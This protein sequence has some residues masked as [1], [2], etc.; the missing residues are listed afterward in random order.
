MGT[1]YRIQE[2]KTGE[3][4]DHSHKVPGSTGSRNGVRLLMRGLTQRGRKRPR[5]PILC[6]YAI[7]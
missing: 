5:A 6:D 7:D 1:M 3:T 2:R 4:L